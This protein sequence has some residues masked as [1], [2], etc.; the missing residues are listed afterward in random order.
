[1][2][3]PKHKT[4]KETGLSWLDKAPYHW[5]IKASKYAMSSCSGGTRIKG[6]CAEE[7][8]ENLIPAFS[9]SG[10]DVWVEVADYSAPGIVLSAVGA[11]CG[12]TF[13]AD[14]KWSVVANTHC[15]FP[16]AGQDRDFLWYLTNQEDW[17]EKEGAA[18]PFVKVKETLGRNWCFPPIEEQMA[19]RAFLDHETTKIDALIT[20]QERL[21]S[22]L[23][24]KRQALISHAVTKGLN[25]DAPIKDSGVEWLGE[26]PEHWNICKGS[27]IGSLFGSRQT[28]NIYTEGDIPF[29]KVST[30][31]STSFEPHQPEWFV[32][33]TDIKIDKTET[34]FLVFPK[35]GEAIFGNKVNFIQSKALIDPNLMGWKIAVASEPIYFAYVLKT[36]KLEEIADVSTV[37]QINNKHINQGY[38]PRPPL[39]EQLEIVKYLNKNIEVIDSLTDESKAAITLLHERRSA[40][41]SAAVTGQI[42]VRGLVPKEATA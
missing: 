34:N 22:L 31:S 20:E 37:P 11:R 32:R 9:A 24:E 7:S 30:L 4:Y 17:W 33:K 27:N 13:K 19:I 1:M 15:L 36:R 28:S 8:A 12:K 42:D 14:G 29:F 40:L 6:S 5:V 35:R 10:Q 26:V 41:I 16:K 38:W 2:S 23:Q 3:F 21:I 25:L 18:Q 39:V